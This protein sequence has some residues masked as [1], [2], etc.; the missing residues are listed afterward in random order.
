MRVRCGSLL[1]GSILVCVVTVL[2]IFSLINSPEACIDFENGG[3][4]KIPALA[5]N[6]EKQAQHSSRSCTVYLKF[7]L[8][9]TD[10]DNFVETTLIK[11]PLSPAIPDMIG[12]VDHWQEQTGWKLDKAKSYLAGQAIGEK[13][14]FLDEQA[15]FVDTTNST[16]YIVYLVTKR[17]W[18]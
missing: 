3:Y 9:P 15:I 14:K 13:D 10:L 6:L 16:Q 1:A 11:M 12:G 17:N 18:L 7:E 4:F 2:L 5:T 8:S